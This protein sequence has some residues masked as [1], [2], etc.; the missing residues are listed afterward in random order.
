MADVAEAEIQFSKAC[1]QLG[2]SYALTGFSAASRIAPMVRYQRMSTF[3]NGE[4]EPI[5][6]AL[7]WKSV[8]S[9]ANVSF[10]MPYY[11]YVFHAAKNVGGSQIVGLVQTYLDLQYSRGRGQE[12]AD[13]IRKELEK[14]W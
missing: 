10:L 14:S 12:A 11:N 4:I 7:G 9:G 3:I 2:Y 13:A 1:E 5:I 6:A 8:S